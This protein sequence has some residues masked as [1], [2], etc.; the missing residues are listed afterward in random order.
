M[1]SLDRAS[2]TLRSCSSWFSVASSSLADWISSLAVCSSS[3]RLCSSS[4]PESG[5]LGG[6]LQLLER[7]LVLAH[8]R[9]HVLGG[10]GQSLAEPRDLVVL[11]V[12]GV[13]RRRRGG[14]PLRARPARSPSRTGRA[15]S[16][17]RPRGP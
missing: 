1:S 15:G 12:G 6:R 14:T 13:H 11:G 17:R 16:V 2:W 10:L 4:L 8:E 7:G 9:V 3:F 5:L